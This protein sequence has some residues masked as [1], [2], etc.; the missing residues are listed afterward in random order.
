VPPA[1]VPVEVTEDISL[2][3]S[4]AAIL[5]LFEGSPHT[6]LH[7]LVKHFSWFCEHPGISKEALSSMLSIQHSM[8]PPGNNLPN[9]YE[10]ALKVIQPF[11]VKPEVYNVCPN[12]CVIFRGVFN[13]MSECPKCSAKRYIGDSRIPARTFTYLPLK[14]RLSRLFNTSSLAQA[15]QSHTVTRSDEDDVMFDIHHSSAWKA[16]YDPDGLFKGDPRGISLAFCTDGVNPFAHNKVVH[17]MWPIMLTLLNLP[18]RIRNL[19]SS[20]LLVGIIPSN[21][22]KEPQSL[23]PYLDILVDEMLEI[24]SCTLYDTYQNAPFKCKAAVLLYVL[25]YPGIGKV[26]SVVG[27]GGFQGCMFCEIEG[28][29]NEDL[30]KMVYVQ[31]RRFLKNDSELRR[32]KR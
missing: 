30:K 9:S 19:F 7:S 31:N 26:M 14:P 8:L 18:R 5:P 11:L 10:A 22:S 15:L 4:G 27:S 29:R 24:C 12:D 6:V 23:A 25:D 16:A 32:D 21:G 13:D 28:S 17:S 1:E 2:Y 3:K 20:I